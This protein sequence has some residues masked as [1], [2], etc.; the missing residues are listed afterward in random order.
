MLLGTDCRAQVVCQH[1]SAAHK[2]DGE[3]VTP[4]VCGGLNYH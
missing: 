4:S 2:L 1:T 3:Q